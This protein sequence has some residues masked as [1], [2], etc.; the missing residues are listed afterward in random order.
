MAWYHPVDDR[1]TETLHQLVKPCRDA[2]SAA[3][4]MAGVGRALGAHLPG[5][6]AHNIELKLRMNRM[7]DNHTQL[8]HLALSALDSGLAKEI[9]E[10]LPVEIDEQEVRWF[11]Y[12][13]ED[14]LRWYEERPQK[15][16]FVAPTMEETIDVQLLY[17]DHQLKMK[18]LI[19]TQDQIVGISYGLVALEAKYGHR[20]QWFS[21]LLDRSVNERDIVRHTVIYRLPRDDATEKLKRPYSVDVLKEDETFQTIHFIHPEFMQGLVSAASWFD[22][23][24]RGKGILWK[25]LTQ[26]TQEGVIEL[27]F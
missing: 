27:D 9:C 25:N 11:Y 6:I 4:T 20:I 5:M 18:R 2:V 17:G 19:L 13:R 1:A 8:I 26:F 3:L 14:V 7:N 22:L 15:Q 12:T 24:D 16:Y 10:G 23:P 21:A